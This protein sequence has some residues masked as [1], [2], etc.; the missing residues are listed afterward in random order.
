MWPQ[1]FIVAL[2]LICVG[3]SLISLAAGGGS[4]RKV[5]TRGG[6][7]GLCGWLGGPSPAVPKDVLPTR[8]QHAPRQRVVR[9]F[10]SATGRRESAVALRIVSE[11]PPDQGFGRLVH[12]SVW[13]ASVVTLTIWL[14]CLGS[15]LLAQSF[16][17][18]PFEPNLLAQTV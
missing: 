15:S 2:L 9:L 4:P 14:K 3:A 10:R 13:N 11:Q 17:L 16:W 1:S 7:G 8:Q 6:S 5:S 12:A 18:E